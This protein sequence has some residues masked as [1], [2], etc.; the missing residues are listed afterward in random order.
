MDIDLQQML[1]D[2]QHTMRML[3]KAHRQGEALQNE[4]N[5]ENL[6]AYQ[7]ELQALL[8]EL[9]ALDHIVHHEIEMVADEIVDALHKSLTNQ[10]A[11]FH[12][13]PDV[14]L[15]DDKEA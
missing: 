15:T 7:A 12:Y 2:I 13:H 6:Q 11:P 3:E 4:P 5:K 8:K 1:E 9:K 10:K 14:K